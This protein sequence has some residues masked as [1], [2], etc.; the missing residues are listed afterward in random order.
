MLTVFFIVIFIAELIIFEKIISVIKN[1]TKSV[2]KINNQVEEIKPVITKHLT[3]AKSGV[4][5][6]TKGVSSASKFLTKRKMQVL[7]ALT[8]GA[9]ALIL[10]LILKKMPN[11][12]VL[13]AVDLIYAI[14]NLAN[15]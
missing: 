10:F 1:C 15:A 11:K 9:V 4:N 12:K 3:T 14:S 13:T 6:V 8:K 2:Q 5:S 7:I